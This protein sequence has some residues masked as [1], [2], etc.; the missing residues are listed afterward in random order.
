MRPPSRESTN[1]P[2][3]NRRVSM[4]SLGGAW[5]SVAMVQT[6]AE[7]LCHW[8]DCGTGLQPVKLELSRIRFQLA[9][10]VFARERSIVVLPHQQNGPLR[11]ISLVADVRRHGGHVAR[12]HDDLG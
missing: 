5:V 1:S 4:S 3:M 7:G 9:A 12:L 10:F 8:F 11:R 6:Q 2:P